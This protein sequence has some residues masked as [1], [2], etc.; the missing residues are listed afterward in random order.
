MAFHQRAET[1]HVERLAAFLGELLRQLD[2]EAVRRDERER[3]LG[4]DRLLAGEVF[5]HLHAARERLGE[6]LL[7]GAHDPLDLLGM[8]AQHRVRVAHLLDDHGGQTVDTIEADALGL[9]D[10]PPQQ[11][12]AD[13]A[14][15]FVRRF[16]PFR[17]QE[18][19]GA[20]M[21]GEHAMRALRHPAL[22]VGDSRL[23]LDPIH[24]HAEAV[25]V[26]HGADVL[27]DT[28]RALDAVACIDVRRRQ[29]HQDVARLQVVR[30]EDEVVDL[31]DPV[32]VAR[33]A[34][35]VAAGVDLPAV[36]EDLGALTARPGFTGLPEVVLPE[37]DD[38]LGG[39]AYTLPRLDRN[40][41]LAQLE[42][43]VALVDGRPEAL[44]LEP[45][46][47]GD[48]FPGEVDG[49]VLVVVAEREV[50]H[51]LEEGAMPVGAAHLVEVVVLP[52]GAQARLDADDAF[53][54]WL[55]GAEEVG[56]ELLHAGDDEERRL[57]LRVRNERV[58]GHAQMTALLVEAL[59]RRAQ[60]VGRHRHGKQCTD[61]LWSVRRTPNLG[62]TT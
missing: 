29:R 10:R 36:V 51:H 13:V 53:A 44:G 3:V 49:L 24:D 38:P 35:R 22:V 39:D 12:T 30:H 31:H 48:P 41:V 4:R 21:V 18:R 5:E 57:V 52:A 8:L 60:L 14:A 55:L 28:G 16:D 62:L 17:D 50:A 26:E 42:H 25:G 19:D 59:K 61:A 37:P 45:Q 40:G 32:A 58:R 27:Q 33:P 9:V 23:A 47:V 56:L 54:R 20:T 6:L 1:V 7:F 2:R 43:R 11:A 34:I 15:A 46:H